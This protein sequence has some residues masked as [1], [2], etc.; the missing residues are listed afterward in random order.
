MVVVVLPADVKIGWNHMG[1]LDEI[2]GYSIYYG[3]SSKN[4]TNHITTGY[5]TNTVISNLPPNTPSFFSGTT[6]G[7]PNL[8]TEFGNEIQFNPMPPINALPTMVK[9]FRLTKVEKTIY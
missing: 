4:Y 8:E 7:H 3:P 6:L 5:V 2:V 1:T 9:D